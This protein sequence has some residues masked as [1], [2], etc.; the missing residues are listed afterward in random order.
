MLTVCSPEFRKADIDK[1][2]SLNKLCLSDEEVGASETPKRCFHF[3][4]EHAMR[5]IDWKM[6]IIDLPE[7]FSLAHESEV[8]RDGMQALATTA[9]YKAW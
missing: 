3:E 2:L 1:P 8:H 9:F 4:Y 6:L 5:P 7:R